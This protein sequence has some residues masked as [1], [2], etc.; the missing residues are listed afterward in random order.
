[1]LQFSVD[2]FLLLIRSLSLHTRTIVVTLMPYNYYHAYSL[3]YILS[4]KTKLLPKDIPTPPPQLCCHSLLLGQIK[5]LCRFFAPIRPFKRE[6]KNPKFVNRTFCVSFKGVSDLKVCLQDPARS[7][8]NLNFY[9]PAQM[10]PFYSLRSQC[11]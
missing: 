3:N 7:C 2:K 4:D 6:K 8:E 5:D 11:S 1:M 9:F 10:K